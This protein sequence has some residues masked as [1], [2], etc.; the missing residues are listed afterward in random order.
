MLLGCCLHKYND[1]HFMFTLRCRQA[2]SFAMFYR[3]CY[4]TGDKLLPVS[5]LSL[6]N[7]R[8][9]FVTSDKLIGDV[10]ELVKISG[11]GLITSDSDNGTNLSPVTM[12]LALVYRRCRPICSDV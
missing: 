1:F 8:R 3:R 5:L 7:Y 9:I 11:Q 10:M 2:D 4:D 12:V 6:I